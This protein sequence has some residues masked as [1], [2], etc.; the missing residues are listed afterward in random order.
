M[1]QA[2]ALRLVEDRRDALL[3]LDGVTGVGVGADTDGATV[4]QVFH[5]PSVGATPL[6][7]RV[8]ALLGDAPVALIG[9]AAPQG[10]STD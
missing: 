2:E 10:F 8:R 6:A 3:A 5:D 4:V 7:S 9:M 1:T